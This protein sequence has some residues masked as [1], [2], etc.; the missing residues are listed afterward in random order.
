MKYFDVPTLIALIAFC[1]IVLLASTVLLAI[2][3]KISLA[4]TV[5]L[6]FMLLFA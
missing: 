5:L 2:C 1:S 4:S 3:L 6:A